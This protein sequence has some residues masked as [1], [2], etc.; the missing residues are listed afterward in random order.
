[1]NKPSHFQEYDKT[2]EQLMQDPIL[3]KIIIV[4]KDEERQSKLS[5]TSVQVR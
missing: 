1:M 4:I 3:S 2:E 5:F